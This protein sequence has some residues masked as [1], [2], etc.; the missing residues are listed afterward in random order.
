MMKKIFTLGLALFCAM[1]S[2][3]QDDFD[4]KGAFEFVDKDGNVIPSGSV[5]T[6]TELE[7]NGQGIMQINSG[8][9]AKQ[10]V[11]DVDGAPLTVAMYISVSRIDHGDIQYCFPGS[12][13]ILSQVA[14]SNT[15]PGK[16][17]T[18]IESIQTEWIPGVDEEDGETPLKGQATAVLSLH[19]YDG[20]IDLGESTS[21]TVNF[22]N[23]KSTG[24]NEVSSDANATV[25]ARYSVDG[26]R[27]SQAQKGLNI[28]KLSNGKTVKYVK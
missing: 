4:P 23:D 1:A 10:V 8:L 14:D 11:K 9:Y 25:V 16:M 19:A 5:L 28:V 2:F 3:A 15:K 18:E 22:V 12:C 26:T 7:E 17:E 21:V 6:R 27:L 13:F 20:D 24:I